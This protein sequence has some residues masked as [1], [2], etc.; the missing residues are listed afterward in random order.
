M[1]FLKENP[2]STSF[3]P[4][5]SVFNGLRRKQASNYHKP[6]IKK[7]I[8]DS[9][10]LITDFKTNFTNMNMQVLINICK[11]VLYLQDINFN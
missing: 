6:L 11:A 5:L 4:V 10:P 7:M 1:L 2:D 8:N 9:F 3:V